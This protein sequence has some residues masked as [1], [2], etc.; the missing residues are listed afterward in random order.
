MFL[1]IYPVNYQVAS[2]EDIFSLIKRDVIYQLLWNEMIS[3]DVAI[4][5]DIILWFFLQN[6]G[7][8][9]LADLLSNL[10]TVAIP[11]EYKPMVVAGLKSISLFKVIKDKFNKYKSEIDESELLDKF[12]D[13][14]DSHTV[15]EED[16]ITAIIKKAIE[17]YS[18]NSNVI[19]WKWGS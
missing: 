6:K 17:Q 19:V 4:S 1:T 14:V 7:V 10:S 2:N 9:L 13:E 11:N 15:Y 5:N 3:D 16:I 18:V 12:L 8:S